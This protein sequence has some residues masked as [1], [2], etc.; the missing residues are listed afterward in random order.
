MV[1]QSSSRG[2]LF[3]DRI[4]TGSSAH[5]IIGTEP[6]TLQTRYAVGPALMLVSANVSNVTQP[7]C[8]GY[9]PAPVSSTLAAA[10]N[11]EYPSRLNDRQSRR[12]EEQEVMNRLQPGTRYWEIDTLRGIAVVLMVLYHFVWDLTYFKLYHANMLAGPWYIFGRTIGSTFIFLLGVSLTL[13]YARHQTMRLQGSS[14]EILFK[15]YL[16]RGVKIFGWGM[17]ITLVTYVVIGRGFVIFG[18]LHLLG[19]SSILAYPFL[20][21]RAWVSLLVGLAIIA[22]GVYLSSVL[23]SFP[24]LIWL[25][26]AQRGV[27]MS[28]YYPLVP[29]FGLVLVG[30]SAG[31]TLYQ[32][33]IRRFTLPDCSNISVVRMLRFLGKHSLV[34]YLLHQPILLALL[35]SLGFGSL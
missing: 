17:V 29:W 22:C 26:L 21:Y 33:G 30:I 31:Y 18:I 19:C 4:T 34:I 7:I 9:L 6:S 27:Y 13:D 23:V 14:S 5:S 28:D 2:L 3:P 16:L 1:G 8:P 11:N 20:W 10:D 25:G 35:M 24:W 12:R 15:R 32:Q